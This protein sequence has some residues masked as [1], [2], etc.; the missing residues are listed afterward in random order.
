LNTITDATSYDGAGYTTYGYEYDPG[1]DGRITWAI[2]GSQTWQL[3][4][5]AFPPNADTEIGQRNIAE[6]P[7]YMCVFLSSSS[8]FLFCALTSSSSSS[9]LASSLHNPRSVLNLAISTKFQQYVCVLLPS[10]AL[11]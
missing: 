5:N 1:S 2:N 8:P 9:L 3:N 7:M 11:R 10:F 4:A 6:E